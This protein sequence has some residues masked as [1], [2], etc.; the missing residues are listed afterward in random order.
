MKEKLK[1]FYEFFL[2]YYLW[3]I[4]GIVTL[5]LIDLSNYLMN[6]PNDFTFYS[7]LF[8]YSICIC[9]MV[10]VIFSIFKKLTKD[11]EEI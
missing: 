4:G 8:L 10:Y 3:F 9:T 11:D 6:Q 2:N 5:K 1:K 7:G